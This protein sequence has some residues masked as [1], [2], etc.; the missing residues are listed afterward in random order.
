MNR[1][2]IPER[3]GR[4]SGARPR[5]AAVLVTVIAASVVTGCRSEWIDQEI[6][7]RH[8]HLF[9]APAG[10][11]SGS[12]DEAPARPDV[13]EPSGEQADLSAYLKYGLT[14]NA[15]LR[16]A[17]DRWRA[18]MEGIPQATALPDPRF[19]FGYFVES[20]ET[21]TGPQDATFALSQTFPWFGKLDA[22][23]DIKKQEANR[24]WALVIGQR[25]AVEQKIR[26]AYFEYAY[27][28]EAVLIS[29]ANLAL[30]QRLEPV[31][32]RKIEGGGRQDDLLRLQVEAGKLENELATLRAFRGPLGARLRAAMN[33]SG[34]DILP[35]PKMGDA[36]PRVIDASGL[37]GALL[38]GNP[39][40]RALREEVRL[41]AARV[42]LAELE[43]WPDLT[44]GANYIATGAARMPGVS[45]SGDDPVNLSLSFNIPIQRGRYDAAVR[46]AG[47]ARA[48]AIGSLRQKEYD[49]LASLDL[50]VY[51]LDD[52]GRQIALYRDS[53]LPRARQALEVAEVGYRGGTATLTDLIDSQR[54]FLAFEKAHQ[55]AR[56]DYEQ[57]LASIDALCGGSIP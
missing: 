14:M 20:I 18:A 47:A 7:R 46:E 13:P 55:R 8:E 10:S 35:W 44:L 51:K 16:S 37:R 26:D 38:E 29:E 17:F 43:G 52:A 11:L 24:L 30:L 33:W 9:G 4:S 45:G 1:T 15:G 56:A 41:Q 39:D 53:L 22:R 25:L 31:I 12:A 28:A 36:E 49:V 23:G 42:D 21:R 2:S 19:T 27:L 3:A 34:S 54:I 57:A 40:L 6:D 50:E 5:R 32:Q 48:S